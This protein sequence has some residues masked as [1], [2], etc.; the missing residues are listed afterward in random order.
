MHLPIFAYAITA[1]A[2]RCLKKIE[3]HGRGAHTQFQYLKTTSPGVL[4][5]ASIK[6]NFTKSLIK[7]N[8]TVYQRYGSLIPPLAIR[9]DIEPFLKP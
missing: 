3:V 1:S 6:W 7:R 9:G 8:G 4:G 2:F 5:T